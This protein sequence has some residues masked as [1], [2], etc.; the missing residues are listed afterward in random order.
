MPRTSSVRP[1]APGGITD[2]NPATTVRRATAFRL[3]AGVGL[4][5]ALACGPRPPEPSATPPPSVETPTTIPVAPA[6]TPLATAPRYD[7][8]WT[9]SLADAGAIQLRRH[10]ADLLRLEYPFFGANWTWAGPGITDGGVLGDRTRYLIDIPGF[11][12]RVEAVARPVEPNVMEVQ[13]SMQLRRDLP[14]IIGGGIEFHL[15]R[16]AVESLAGHGDPQ[17]LPD[18]AGFSWEV[19]DGET[20]TVRFDPPLPRVYFERGRKEQI[21]AFL[22][23]PGAKAG[24]HVITMRVELPGDG[25]VLPSNGERYASGGK[26]R[27][28]PSTVDWDGMPVDLRYLND[29]HRPAG[30][31]G[32]V[33]VDGDTLAFADGTPARFWGT[34]VTAFSLYNAD[35]DTIAATA[36]RI[37]A[38]GFNL[39]RLHH[40]DSHW[41]EPNIFVKDGRDTQALSD[42]ALASLDWWVKCLEDEGIYVWLDLHVGRR[43]REGDA[44]PGFSE[45]AASE[46]DPKGFN[47]FNPRIEALMAD[48]AKR[49][50][51]RTNRFTKRRYTEDPGIMGVLLTNENDITHHFGNKM[52]DNAGAPTHRAMMIAA[53]RPFM[54]ANKMPQQALQPWSYG[55][56]KVLMNEL[57]ARWNLRMIDQLRGLG[58]AGPVATTNFW[59]D[60]PMASLPALTVGDVLDVHGYGGEGELDSNPLHASNFVQRI[61]AGRVEGMPT[62]ITEWNLLPPVRDRFVGPIWF[63]AV[64]RLQGWDAPMHFCY[65]NTELPP[66]SWLHAG[67]GLI[68]PATMALMPAAALVFREGHADPARERYRIVMKREDLYGREMGAHRSAA[69]RTLTERSRVEIALPDLPELRWD[70]RHRAPKGAIAVTDLDKSFLADDATEIVSDT[71]QLRRNW[72]RGVG[73]LDTPRTQAAYGWIGGDAIALSDVEIDVDT[74]KGTVAVTALD[75]L[76]IRRSKDLLVTVVSEID[77]TNGRPPLRARAVTGKLRIRSEHAELTMRPVTT[78]SKGAARHAGAKQPGTRDGEQHEFE[79]YP[80]PTHWYRITAP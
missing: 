67:M 57:E 27:W 66:P 34:N 41:V 50:L 48:F 32:R 37:A 51:T 79:L 49:Y 44:I 12:A 20:V 46:R 19:A 2:S 18:N 17:L 45:L 23:G 4:V 33:E 54:K 31:H 62:T 22:L 64:A 8:P 36:R 68:D 70:G 65:T 60:D 72:S 35:R 30:V 74:P 29:G 28:H 59:G 5:T 26:A 3:M 55:P 42:D 21:R 9:V 25:A 43:M 47:Y 78:G 56:A 73:T 40:H 14:D 38:L 58:F 63:A 80:L 52:N 1:Q 61:A 77:S 15:Q 24:N 69:I 76:P 16:Y 13:Y 6:P 39:V 7:A 71:G 53:A 10:H 11:E 75:G